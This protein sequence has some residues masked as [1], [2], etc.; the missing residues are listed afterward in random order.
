MKAHIWRSAAAA[1]AILFIAGQARA[2]YTN[3]DFQT[4]PNGPIKL[5]NA[6]ATATA[7]GWT[8][9]GDA[10]NV[11]SQPVNGV[12][13]LDQFVFDMTPSAFNYMGAGSWTS[14]SDGNGFTLAN[15]GG[16]LQVSNVANIPLTWMSSVYPGPTAFVN[17]TDQLPYINIGTVNPGPSNSVPF[18][19]TIVQ[20]LPNFNNNYSIPYNFD[21][22]GSFVA[23][24][25][26]PSTFVL[27]GMGA[28][29][30]L[31]FVRRRN[32]LQAG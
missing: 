24:V 2:Q 30:S 10:T 20:T 1:V 17:P 4:L 5:T 7:N 22:I 11:G 25:P 28:L 16:Y 18:S 9:T 6:V 29:G 15:P 8:L 26:E 14:L 23:P 32:R 21:F 31:V 27:L 19:E 13:L 12:V 3:V